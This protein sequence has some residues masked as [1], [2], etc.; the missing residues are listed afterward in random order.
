MKTFFLATL[1]LLLASTTLSGVDLFERDSMYIP[2][3]ET[4]MQIGHSSRGAI[5]PDGKI[6]LFTTS[7]TDVTQL[8]RRT[9]EGWPYQLT[10]FEEG[11]DWYLPS[12]DFKYAILGVSRGGNEQSQLY[13]CDIMTG[14]LK[15]LTNSPDVQYGY[16]VWSQDGET[17]YFRSNKTNGQDFQVWKINL[18]DGEEILVQG[19]AGYNGPSDISKD[20]RYLLTYTYNSNV[21][22]DYFL[23][24]LETGDEDLLTPHEGDALF[25][26]FNL[27]PDLAYAY[28]TTNNNEDGIIRLAKLNMETKELEF[29]DKDSEWEYEGCVLSDDSRYIGWIVNEG[30]YAKAY[31]KDL[32]TD[33]MLPAPPL[34]GIIGGGSL[35]EVKSALFEFNSPTKAPDLWLWEWETETLTQITFSSYAGIDPSVFTEP[36]LIRYKSF[37]GLEIPAF[38]YLP[39]DYNGGPIPFIVHAHGGPEGQYRPYFSRHFTYLMLHGYGVL[40]VNPRGSEGYGREYKAMDDYKKRLDSVKDYAWAAKWLIRNG[41]TKESM[42]GIKGGSYGG[43]VVMASLT[44][45]PSLYRAGLDYIGIVNFVT[46]LQNTKAYRRALREAEYGPLTDSTFLASISPIHKVDKI[47]AALL[48]VHGEN[49]PRVPVGEARQIIEAMEARGAEVES[50]IY[51]DEGHGASKLSNRLDYYRRMVDF[52]DKYLK[53]K[54]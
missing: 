51:P 16:P 49:D 52:F 41:Y 6:I 30:G 25:T 22:N 7:L 4:F 47:K 38:L 5:S 53:S 46:F 14:R 17:I 8:F 35:S 33:Q 28:V 21:D 34:E 39:A 44:E 37:D 50:V 19:K 15:Q 48:V 3:I 29:L 1:T 18:L 9:P 12:D 40:A 54:P 24:D 42:L 2:D 31:L 20:G 36:K 32:E 45:Y 10:V 23:L 11:I 27:T 43:Y 13:L 26:S